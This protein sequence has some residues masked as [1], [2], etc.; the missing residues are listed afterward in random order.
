MKQFK[1]RKIIL[2]DPYLCKEFL[3]QKRIKKQIKDVL[4]I[5]LLFILI[6]TIL[7][8]ALVLGE[9]LNG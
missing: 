7:P 9:K 2:G 4:L 5:S 8:W 1:K 6:L 3:K